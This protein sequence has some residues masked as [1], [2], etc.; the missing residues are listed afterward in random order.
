MLEIY[1]QGHHA[2]VPGELCPDCASL[3]DYAMQRLERCPFQAGKPACARCTV[4]CYRK[5]PRAAVRQVMRYAGPR[6]LYRHPGLAWQHLLDG[7]RK[8]PTLKKR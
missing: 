4:H 7:L 5:D 2:P 6:M 1:C 3:L 8:P